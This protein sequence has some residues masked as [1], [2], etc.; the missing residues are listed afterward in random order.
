MT[1]SPA[2]AVAALATVGLLLAGCSSTGD[3]APTSTPTPVGSTSTT[4]TP[5]P[6][7]S[8]SPSSALPADQQQAFEETPPTVRPTPRF[9]SC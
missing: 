9:C 7:V 3:P 4:A 6:S 8:P 1:Y 5:S 2:R